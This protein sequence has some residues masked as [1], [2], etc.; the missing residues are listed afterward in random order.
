MRP[1]LFNG[2]NYS[3]RKTRMKLFIQTNN[4]EV[5]RIITNGSLIPMKRVEGVIIPKEE[6]EWDN[7]DS[8]KI[9]LNA[10]AMYTLFCTLGANEYNR[11]SLCN[12]AK[13]I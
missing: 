11:I 5:W 4:Y 13:E 9:Q 12:N 6:G 10:K 8:I 2:S 1:H 3:Y 7:N